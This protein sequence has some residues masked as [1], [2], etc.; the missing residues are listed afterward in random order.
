MR[1]TAAAMA[2]IGLLIATATP[3]DAAPRR[4]DRAVEAY[5]GARYFS[6]QH[7]R[8]RARI[9]VRRA[10]TFLDPGTEVLPLSQPYTDYALPLGYHPIQVVGGAATPSGAQGP[11][12]PAP[13]PF[14]YASP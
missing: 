3:G 7:S 1:W 14:I 10:R 8:P 2:G 4:G 12:W 11:A 5:P 6:G 9:T 13:R